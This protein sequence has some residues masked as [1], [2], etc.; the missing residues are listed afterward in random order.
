MLPIAIMVKVTPVVAFIPLFIIWLGY[1]WQPK[2]AIA[3]LITY[4]PVS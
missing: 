1:G 4:F 3:A 2:I